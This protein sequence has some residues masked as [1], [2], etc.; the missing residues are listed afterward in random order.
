MSIASLWLLTLWLMMPSVYASDTPD[1]QEKLNALHACR[2]QPAALERLDCYDRLLTPEQPGSLTG[3]ILK[4]GYTGEAWKRAF[5]QEKQ[6]KDNSTRLLITHTEGERPTVIIT[7]PAIGIPPPRPILMFSCIDNITRMQV[8]LVHP[9]KENDIP[10]TLNA[11]TRQ[12]RSHWF[13]RENSL[14]LEASRG[15]VGIDEIKR[16][17]GAKTLTI[18]T[19]MGGVAGKLAFNT[20]GLAQA[21]TPLR[22]ACHWAE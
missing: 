3:A 18:D 6:R 5:A 21:I 2:K 8:A 17:F 15:L 7:A 1:A 14:L 13:V 10:V 19:G 12:F 4:P 20:D 22:S 11:D 9:L 16:L